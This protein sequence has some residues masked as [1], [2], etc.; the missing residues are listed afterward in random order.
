ML[1]GKDHAQD[2]EVVLAVEVV[3]VNFLDRGELVDARVV[4]EDVEPAER[5]VRFFEEPCDVFGVRQV[6][7]HGHRFAALG[8]DLG[9][10]CVG[11]SLARTVV[12]N[13]RGA[14]GC[15]LPGDL[16]ADA[17]GRAGDDGDFVFE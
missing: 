8:F 17:L 3:G 9:D 1:C 10:D 7:L 6:G 4:H 13:D 15:Q 2:V 14:A 5:L 16:R 12:D 11:R